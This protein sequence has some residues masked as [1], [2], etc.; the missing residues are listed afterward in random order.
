MQSELEGENRPQEEQSRPPGAA[1]ADVGLGWQLRQTGR[2]EGPHPEA[3]RA[4]AVSLLPLWKEGLPEAVTV[5]LH[6]LPYSSLHPC[7]SS[8]TS[9][10]QMFWDLTTK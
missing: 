3:G 9:S 4:D 8:P 5:R 10:T 2:S 6:L 1:E 7:P